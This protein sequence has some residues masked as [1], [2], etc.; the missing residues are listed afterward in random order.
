MLAIVFLLPIV[1]G[2]VGEGRKRWRRKKAKGK[3]EVD[4]RAD[5]H[6]IISVLRRRFERSTLAVSLA[7]ML[8]S[9]YYSAGIIE[10][11]TRRS[12]ALVSGAKDELVLRRY[13]ERLIIQQFDR[14][15][16]RPIGSFRTVSLNGVQPMGFRVENFGPLTFPAEN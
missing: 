4:D 15:T 1:G 5:A 3:K 16:K 9:F 11:Q 7:V 12:F 10:A 8:S 6:G 13:G 14:I 2:V